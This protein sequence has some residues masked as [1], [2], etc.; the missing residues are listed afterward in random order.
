[1]MQ[2]TR[3]WVKSTYLFQTLFVCVFPWSVIAAWTDDNAVV[4]TLN[5]ATA[6][7]MIAMFFFIKSRRQMYWTWHNDWKLD[8]NDHLLAITLIQEGEY[9]A[10]QTL[11]QD[12]Y[13]RIMSRSV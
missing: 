9:V 6:G 12:M 10:Y 1:M 4:Q 7:L 11:W 8:H 2:D 13:Q 3:K 5:A